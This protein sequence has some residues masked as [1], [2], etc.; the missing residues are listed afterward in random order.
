MVGSL[1][2]VIWPVLLLAA[3]ACAVIIIRDAAST[4]PSYSTGYDGTDPSQCARGGPAEA[5]VVAR[6]PL[7]GDRSSEIGM[8][9]LRRSRLC[10][11]EWGQIALDPSA[12]HALKGR[13]IEITAVRP[14]DD[15]HAPYPL[16][17]R[18]GNVGFGNQLGATSCVEAQAQLLPRGMASGGPTT[19]TPCT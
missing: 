8:L 3:V 7:L 6:V 19:T 17:L 13:T 18:G 16:L 14:A 10:A 11:T 12:A 2:R 4:T 15:R 9:R 5:P 1:N